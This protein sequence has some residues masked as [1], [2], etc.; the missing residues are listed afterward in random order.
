MT[1]TRR[2]RPRSATTGRGFPH[3][4]KSSAPWQIAD[5]EDYGHGNYLPS[6]GDDKWKKVADF[7]R[8]TFLRLPSPWPG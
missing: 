7:M 3:R 1:I 2:L 5:A 4:H 6:D 8:M